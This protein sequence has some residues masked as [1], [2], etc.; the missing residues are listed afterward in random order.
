MPVPGC[1]ESSVFLPPNNRAKTQRKPPLITGQKVMGSGCLSQRRGA[2]RQQVSEYPESAPSSIAWLA[3]CCILPWRSF[4]MA[5][6]RVF[7]GK[8]INKP[9]Q[10]QNSAAHQRLASTG[11]KALSHFFWKIR[12]RK[13]FS[14]V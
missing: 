12:A 4:N 13:R 3:I 11:S 10:S 7:I 5:L 2:R 9:P 6:L 1:D 8:G 14:S